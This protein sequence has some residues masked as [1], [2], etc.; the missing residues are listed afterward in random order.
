MHEESFLLGRRI[1]VRIQHPFWDADLVDLLMKI[2][3]HVRIR[4]G[5]TKALERSSLIRRFPGL[6]FESQRKGWLRNAFLSAVAAEA[7]AARQ[8][9]AGIRTIGELGIVDLAQVNVYLDDLLARKG[10]QGVM[11]AWEILN[12]EAWARAHYRP[13]E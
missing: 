9:M 8:A 2:R 10:F 7:G 1:G 12:L 3:P 13:G 11:Q 4:G 5:L 6:G